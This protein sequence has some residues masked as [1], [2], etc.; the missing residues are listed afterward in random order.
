MST[1]NSGTLTPPMRRAEVLDLFAALIALALL[2]FVFASATGGA[3][4]LLT[5]VFTFFVPGHAIVSNWPRLADWSDL[6]MSIVLSLATLVLLATVSLWLQF[7]HPVGLFKLE[8][9]LSLI[10]LGIGILRRRRLRKTTEN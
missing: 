5:L 6:G 1:G 8:A 10:G 4:L 2:V 9:V 7:W 3:R